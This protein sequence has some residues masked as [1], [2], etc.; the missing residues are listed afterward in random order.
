MFGGAHAS[1]LEEGVGHLGLLLSTQSLE[2]IFLTELEL[3]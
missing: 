3:G 1:R 2:M